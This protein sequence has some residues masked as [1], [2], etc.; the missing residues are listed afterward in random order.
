MHL[1]IRVLI[2][3]A[4]CTPSVGAS[5]VGVTGGLSS[6]GAPAVILT[7]PPS[8]LLDDVGTNHAM[9][10]FDE[11]QGVKT[12]L[13]YS[14]DG[15]GVIP[16]GSVVNSHMIFLNSDGRVRVT[17]QDVTWTF[18]GEILGVMSDSAGFLEA[19]SSGELG[20]SET[21]YTQTSDGSGEAAPYRLRGLESSDK[22]TIAG[23][24]LTISMSVREPGDWIRVI[25]SLPS[26]PEPGS[27]AIWSLMG[28]VGIAVV[29]RHR[30]R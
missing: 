22:Y 30:K 17:H 4:V 2:L 19:F 12:T 10:G 18:D 13:A 28:C 8:H 15:G 24:L 20:N 23:N 21:N 14:V 3:I 5:I 25:T 9:Q 6:L 27:M 16:I 26:V 1:G 29:W 11:A 7:T